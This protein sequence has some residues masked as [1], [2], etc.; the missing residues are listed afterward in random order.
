MLD[1]YRYR[2]ANKSKVIWRCCKNNCASCARSDGIEYVKAT[3]HVHAPNQEEI[4]SMEFKSVINT[5]ATISHDLPRR[6]IHEVLLYENNNDGSAVP[7]YPSTQRT[8]ERKRKQQDKPLTSLNDTCIPDELRVTNDSE[9]FL[10]HD[11]GHSD[12]R[13]IILL[14]DEDLDRLS[15]SEH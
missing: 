7:N 10:L 14:S 13:S 6:I 12:H 5:G 1:G 3:G 8:I 9:R 15:N 11:N 4:I 2:H